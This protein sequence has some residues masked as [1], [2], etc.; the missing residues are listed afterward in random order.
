MMMRYFSRWTEKRLSIVLLW[1]LSGMASQASAVDLIAFGKSCLT[2]ETKLMTLKKRIDAAELTD[3]RSQNIRFGPRENL[4]AYQDELN[5]L[6]SDLDD[7]Q[8]IEPNSRYCH[9]I[10]IRYNRL[11][12]LVDR[13]EDKLEERREKHDRIRP[14]RLYFEKQHYYEA[15]DKFIA[16]CRN[17]DTHYKLLQDGN[18]YR[19]VCSSARLKNTTTCALF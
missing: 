10:R 1:V 12:V 14:Q 4:R 2:Q 16:V 11:V 18:A 5:E 7:C 3:T 17:S 13:S 8:K 19:Q 6:N 15:Y 9:N